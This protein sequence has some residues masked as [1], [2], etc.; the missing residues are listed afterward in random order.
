[1]LTKQ[2]VEEI[3]SIY[4]E[5]WEKKDTSKILTIFTENAIYQ[6]KALG[7]PLRG[8]SEIMKYWDERVVQGQNNIDFKVNTIYIDGNTAIVEWDVKFD[9]L[10]RKVRKHLKEVAILKIH[11]GKIS[12]FHEYWDS[13]V[14]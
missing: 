13:E 6:E 11:N 9:D 14:L 7:K 4:Q 3:V 5:S 10:V 1:M 8:I 12:S 2:K